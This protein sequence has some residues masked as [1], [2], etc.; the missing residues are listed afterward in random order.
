[1]PDKLPVLSIA[2]GPLSLVLLFLKGLVG[3]ILG[4]GCLF[5][6]IGPGPELLETEG[7]EHWG[8]P[9]FWE[10]GGQGH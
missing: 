3:T 1:V 10:Q 7:L 2:V 8:L 4:D 6:A 5:R 9:S